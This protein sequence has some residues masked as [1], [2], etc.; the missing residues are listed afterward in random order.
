MLDP[1]APTKFTPLPAEQ[2]LYTS[3]PRTSFS[4]ETLG[5]YPAHQPLSLTSSTGTLYLTNKRVLYIP[6]SPTPALQSF[7]A[8]I[9]NLA[10]SHV[11]TPW[12]GPNAWTA[13]VRP[14]Q[15]G[16]LPS[17]QSA[18]ELKLTFKDG[19][20]YDFQSRYERVR[21]RL[22]QAVEVA[23]AS[24]VV[25]GDGADTGRG[26]GGSALDGV[27]MGSVHLEELPR[28]EESSAMRQVEV[29]AVMASTQQGAVQAESSQ[30][31]GGDGPAHDIDERPVR[32]RASDAEVAFQSPSD[33]P[34]SYE[35]VQREVIED[36]F[37][38]RLEGAKLDQ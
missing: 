35:N 33:P 15:G 10:D 37:S 38:R 26:A 22:Q 16:G 3:P 18:L 9:L 17:S 34:P 4:L 36:E 28:Y 23:R 11:T 7:A 8:S 12:F 13:L 5:K 32:R 30:E 19:G 24:G 1:S 20:A 25:Q 31:V 6:S 14:V 27:N 29:P 21:E 2:T